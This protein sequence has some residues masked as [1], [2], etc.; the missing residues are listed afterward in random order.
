[1]LV[2]LFN[3]NGPVD[4]NVGTARLYGD[5]GDYRL[6]VNGAEWMSYNTYLQPQ[7][8]TIELFSHWDLAYGDCILSGLGLGLIANWIA[9]KPEVTSVKVYEISEDIITLNSLHNTLHE[10]IQII[11]API[12]EARNESCNCLLLDHYEKEDDITIYLDVRTIANTIPCD[13]VWFWR[14]E[15]AI[16]KWIFISRNVTKMELSHFMML[17]KH[18]KQYVAIPK[19]PDLTEAKLLEYLANWPH[20]YEMTISDDKRMISIAPP[21]HIS[22]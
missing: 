11:N 10:K 14:C 4:I 20:F 8:Q 21:A 2:D 7:P 22:R 17:Y 16:I 5:K 15:P 18:W 6:T 12:Q 1:M 9:E 13:L 3:K 19:L